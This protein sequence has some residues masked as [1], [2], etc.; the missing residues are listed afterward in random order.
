MP[1][2]STLK[3][4]LA[5]V[6]ERWPNLQGNPTAATLTIWREFYEHAFDGIG[7]NPTD[8]NSWTTDAVRVLQLPSVAEVK[9]IMERH[10]RAAFRRELEAMPP[11]PYY[12]GKDY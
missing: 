4:K 12:A 3:S 10:R 7:D 5:Y 6:I 9:K 2:F 1:K 11:A 8:G